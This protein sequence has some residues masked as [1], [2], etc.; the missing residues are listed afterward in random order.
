[1]YFSHY[2]TGTNK[3]LVEKTGL[4]IVSAREETADEDGIPT[5]FLWVVA[6]KS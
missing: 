4:R 1:M 3:R 6:R 2:D 5:T